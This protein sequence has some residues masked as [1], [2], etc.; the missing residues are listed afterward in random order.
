MRSLLLVFAAILIVVPSS[1]AQVDGIR[2]ATGMPLSVDARIVF[3]RVTV[4]G[5]EP[6]AK[7]PRINIVLLDRR[8]QSNRTI[9]DRNGYFYFRDVSADGATV[10]VEIE[11][12]EV[13]RQTLMTV[14]P[15]QQRMDF[16]VTV[17]A[18]NGQAKPGTIS[19]KNL[20]DRGKD[21]S[22]LMSKAVEAMENNRAEKAIPLLIKVIETD[23]SDHP[24]WA[25]L[26]AAYSATGE[27]ENAEKAFFKALEIKPDSAPALTSLGRFYMSQKRFDQA[28]EA[29]EKAIVAEP[30][31]A[32]AFRLLG[33]SYLQVRK[34]SKAIPALN[35]AIRLQPR[36]MADCH[37][38]LAKLY[39]IVGARHLASVE[40]TLLLEKVPDHPEKGKMKRY[41]K[42]NPPQPAQ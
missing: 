18:K 29:F 19:A 1:L 13:A 7:L 14:G 22:S 42:N 38:L 33:E 5:L 17:P 31:S 27:A 34:G 10:V 12:I 15:K 4:E 8:L 26:G 41:I 37:M 9:L 11:G 28:I 16:F 40:F 36:E 6:G 32:S 23:P 2:E 3:G 30:A 25:I 39:D 35:E 20:Y 24:A 21:N